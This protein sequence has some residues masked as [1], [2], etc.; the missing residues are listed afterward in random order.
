M[1]ETRVSAK[2]SRMAETSCAAES[3]PPPCA[4]K[5]SSGPSTGTPRMADQL[6]AS[7]A[8][9]GERRSEEHTSE[10]QSLMRISYDV[11]CLKKKKHNKIEVRINKKH[12]YK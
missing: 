2:R 12:Q 7:Q 3:D 5:S 9:V 1:S 10:L 8:A 6:S 4:K 11:F